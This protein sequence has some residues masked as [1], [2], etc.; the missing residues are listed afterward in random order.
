MKYFILFLLFPLFL[1]AVPIQS[2]Y[3]LNL[4]LD[5]ESDDKGGLKT[6][7]SDWVPYKLNKFSPKFLEDYYELYGLNLHYG[8]ND[9]RKDIYFLKIGLA[10]RF[11]H[12]R[13][14]LC[15]IK[16]EESYYKYRLLLTMHL[17]LQIMRAYMR[18]GSLYDKRFV[19]FHNLDFA[20]DLKKSFNLARGFYKEAIPYWKAAKDNAMKAHKLTKDLDLGTLESERYEIA[21]G[22][23]NFDFIIEDHLDRLDKKQKTVEEYLKKNPDADKPLL[24]SEED[25][26]NQKVQ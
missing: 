11:R 9:L 1:H 25:D 13:N 4:D 10:S 22:K 18:I 21:L 24:D 2:D 20:H 26:K 5:S 6:K 8:E 23:L 3:R 16:D 17:N 12:P 14:S 15:E 7:F 19:Y